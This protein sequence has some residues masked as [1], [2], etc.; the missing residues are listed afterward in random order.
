MA[1]VADKQF[2]ELKQLI[3]ISSM[4]ERE[5]TR[6]KRLLPRMLHS[7]RLRLKMNL[8]QQLLVDAQFGTV[9]EIMETRKVPEGR[10]GLFV[11]VLTKILEKTDEVEEKTKRVV[12]E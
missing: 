1:L 4:S 9:N 2:E 7:E 12:G 11:S 8:L 3:E 10:Q 6:W 5:K